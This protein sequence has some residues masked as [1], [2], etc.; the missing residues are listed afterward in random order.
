MADDPRIEQLLE[1]LLDSN[2]TP[3]QV[4][5]TCPELLPVVRQR[6]RQIRRV[7][8]DLDALFPLREVPSTNRDALPPTP[9]VPTPP[10]PEGTALPQV[11]GYAVEAVLGQG[12]MGIVFRARH[13]RLNRPVALK[14]LLAGPYARPQELERFQREAEAVAGLRHPNVVQVYDVGD[15]DGRPYFTMELVEGGSLADKLAGTPCP[16]G[17]AAALVAAVAE[18]IQAAHQCGIVH[19]DLKPANVLL[20]GEGTP[21]V[22]DFGLARR[23][24]GG[25]GLTL[26]GAAMGTPSYMA[27]EQARGDKGTIGPATDVYA[28]GVVLYECLTGRPPFRADTATATLRQ[29]VEE[30]PVPPA[31]LNP[32]VPRD[33]ETI[34]LKC[35]QKGPGQR[36]VSAAALADDLR[37]FEKGEP[38]TAR[39]PGA[40]ERAA[41]WVRRRPTAAALLAAGLLMLAGVI[42]A[43]VWYAGDRAR[44]RAEAHGRAK[45]AT[46]ALDDAEMHLKD[47]R[48][49]L[50]GAP[51]AWD[52]LSDIDRW[53][54]LVK[55]ARQDWQRAVAAVGDDALMAEETRARIQAVEDAVAREQAAYNLAK[56]L[57]DIAVEAFASFDSQRSHQRKAVAKFE[58]LFARQGMDVHQPGTAWFRSAVESSP[59]RFALIAALDNRALLADFVKDARLARFLELAREADPDPWRDRFRKP[60]VWADGD[61]LAELAV[62][63]E[64]GRQSPSVL[65]SLGWLL[66]LNGADPTALFERALVDHPRDFWLLLHTALATQAPG[67]KS[68]LAQAALAVRPG[69]A[70]AYCLLAVGLRERRD[71]PA[72]VA[73]AMRAI[74]IN[75]DYAVAHGCLGLALRDK[76]DLPG[77]VAALKRAADLDSHSPGA[78]YFLGEVFLLQ[79]NWAAAAEAYRKATDRHLRAA[80]FWKLGGCPQDLKNFL[81]KLK[82]Y[83]EVVGAFRRTIELDPGDF[84]GRYILGQVLQQQGRYGEA[85]QLYL[86]ALQAQANW[87]PACDSLARLLATCPDD[88][89]RDGKRAIKYAT[90]ACEQTAWEDPFC[91]DT[92]AA[93]YAEAGQFEEAVRYQTRALET[94]ALRDYVLPAAKERL[95]L[96]R[97]KKPFRDPGP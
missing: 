84:L 8:A 35:L 31:R 33:L 5:A 52:L 36:Y 16:A 39:P 23:L 38:I 85:E 56:E 64:V 74:D 9:F 46:A 95:E 72:A 32:R 17:P 92:L 50:D 10:P 51:Q 43:A 96:Y 53:E 3:E 13:L 40:L 12:G 71:L 77:A 21:K 67:V 24:D 55:Q 78:C 37:R 7:E 97:Q 76:K 54:A 48:A 81:L 66:R 87:L 60:A 75:P 65:V 15:V 20:T 93:A 89:V 86:G 82:D 44:L 88:E 4:C 62:E 42:A 1:E 79:E 6:W 68:G 41:R 69:S 70:E 27:P 11:P 83:P 2:A 30:E 49:K 91:Q 29:V 57:D 19:R 26:T 22:T 61:A 34:C 47:L 58:R 45:L 14:M 28:L 59:V 94:P 90:T 18:A 63:A 25:E 73:A 80:A